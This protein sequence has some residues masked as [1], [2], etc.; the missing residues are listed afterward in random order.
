MRAKFYLPTRVIAGPGCVK[1]NAAALGALGSRAV[2]VTGKSSSKENGSLSDVEEALGSRGVAYAVYDGIGPNPGLEDCRGAARTIRA[3]DADFLVAIGGGSP[4]DA[5][6]AAAILA[7]NE[8]SDDEAFSG[9][10][11]RGALPIAAVP[12]TAGTGSEVTQY[13]ILTN[14]KAGTK[15]SIAWE[16]IFPAVAFLD[17]RY[18]ARLPRQVRINT[19]LDALSHAA[20]GYLS[21]RADDWSRALAAEALRILGR[22]LPKLALGESGSD[23][24]EAL[25]LAA[26]LAGAVIAQT[27]T[28]AVHAMGY[29]LTYRKGI[30][31]GRANGLLLGAFLDYARGT[32]PEASQAVLRLTGFEDAAG[33]KALLDRLLGKRE[34]LSAMELREFAAMASKTKHIAN[35]AGAPDEATLAGLYAASLA[36]R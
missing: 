2:V 30:D 26:N 18:L 9:N 3:F 27:A 17:A 35:T 31:H 4:L 7:R 36:V 16:G 34:S 28:T 33:F 1:A 6:K 13:A 5:A 20:E 19:A 14:D 22:A 24:D 11:P 8:L 29:S 10:Y 25:L 15:S 23:L 12:T 21:L 32:A